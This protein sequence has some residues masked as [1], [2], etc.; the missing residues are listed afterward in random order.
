MYCNR[1][2]GLVVLSAT[3]YARGLGYNSQVEQKE[4]LGFFYEI[5]S[6]NSE[7]GFV[8][9]KMAIGSPSVSWD[10]KHTGELWEIQAWW[11]LSMF[12]FLM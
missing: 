8:P 9:G 10:L 12:F 5:L 2:V 1:L 3:G 4:L 7:L 6:S 11:Y